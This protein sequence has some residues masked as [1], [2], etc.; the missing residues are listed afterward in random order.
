LSIDGS[1]NEYLLGMDLEG[2]VLCN[3]QMQYPIGSKKGDFMKVSFS[4][5]D[6]LELYTIV[7]E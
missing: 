7:G 6:N 5:L 4:A 2:G 3:W 1:F